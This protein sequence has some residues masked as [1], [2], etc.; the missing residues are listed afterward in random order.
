MVT[1]NQKRLL[2]PFA[3]FAPAGQ[4]FCPT[5][6]FIFRLRSPRR[7]NAQA[8]IKLEGAADFSFLVVMLNVAQACPNEGRGLQARLLEERQLVLSAAEGCPAGSSRFRSRGFA[9]P[10]RRVCFRCS[11]LQ[12][13]RKLNSELSVWYYP[14]CHR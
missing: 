13:R 9:V 7:P 11:R 12:G 6:E 14:P 2:S 3:H 1:P 5:L 10:V 8:T 4:S